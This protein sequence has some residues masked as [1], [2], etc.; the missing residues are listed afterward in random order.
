MEKIK[1]PTPTVRIALVGKYV[2]LKDAYYSVRES[3]CHAAIHNGR[4]IQIDWVHA[5][6]IEKNGPE[7]YLKHVQGII[8]PG[9]FGIRGIEGMISAVKYARENG[10]P[11]LGLCLGMQVMVI[12][13][14]R[15]VLGSDKAHSTEFEPDSPYPVIDLLPE[16]RGVDS[17]GGTMRLGNY[18]VLSSRVP[19]LGRHT[20]IT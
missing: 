11:Y 16:Q 3:L 7:E 4:D 9:G 10:I 19:W 6:D 13:F 18:P 2:E 20:G 1:E 5:E 8:I 17:K 12:E 14:A 15:Y